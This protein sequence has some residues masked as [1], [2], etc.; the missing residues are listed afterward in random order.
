[1]FVAKIAK[2]IEYN[3]FLVFIWTPVLLPFAGLL[4]SF[5]NKVPIGGEVVFRL[6]ARVREERKSHSEPHILTRGTT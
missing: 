2:E 5:P 6:P 1:M 4:F 3:N